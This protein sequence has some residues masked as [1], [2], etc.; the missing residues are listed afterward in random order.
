[1]DLRTALLQ[2]QQLL[3]RG[4]IPS[5]RLTAEVLLTHATRQSRAWLYA[6]SG[7][8]LKEVWWIHY[9]RYLHERLQGKPLQYI[10]G[11]QEFYGRE[12]SVTPAVL[13]PRPETE[14]LVEAAL[15]YARGRVL[16]IGTG[17]GI[18]AVTVALESSARVFATD[19]SPSALVVARQNA[20]N[21]GASVAFV[22]CD[23]ASA[24]KGP[25]DLIV[26]NPPYVPLKDRESLQTEVR[27]WE[28]ELALFG[29][30]EGL[31]IYRRLIPQAREKLCEGGWLALEIG[32]GQDEAVRAMLEGWQQVSVLPDLA[33]IPRVIRA[34]LPTR[35]SG[36]TTPRP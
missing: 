18:L 7:E 12:F 13:I 30:E 2:G 28:P 22:A 23:L 35:Q 32:Q 15:P 9:G 26:S 16:D 4:G 21:L 24:L 3:E 1:M 25:F 11:A 5:P 8:E 36:S 31:D 27:D 19:L 33:G 10:L 20:R 34:Q 6:H 17:S 29:G 14:H